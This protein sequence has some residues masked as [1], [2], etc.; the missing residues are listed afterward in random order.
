MFL[1]S[2]IA[3]I[4]PLVAMERGVADF[5]THL[6]WSLVAMTTTA[7]SFTATATAASTAAMK[8]SIDTN[9]L[10]L[11]LRFNPGLSDQELRV[12]IIQH[13]WLSF[14]RECFNEWIKIHV[15]T[16]QN[17]ADH[18][19]IIKPFTTCRHFISKTLHLDVVCR[20]YRVSHARAGELGAEMN[21]SCSRL[22]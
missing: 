5:A 1:L 7:A 9:L 8:C 20:T 16:Y 12:Q 6:A 3:G 17:V 13:L 10:L 15:K 11:L 21:N 4:K 14:G 18:L 19:F 2:I 22:G